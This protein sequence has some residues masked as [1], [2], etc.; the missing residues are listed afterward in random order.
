VNIFTALVGLALILFGASLALHFSITK[1]L[2]T[3]LQPGWVGGVLLLLIQILYI[4]NL[5]LH[6]LSYFLG[7]GF[8]IGAETHLSPTVFTI[9][10]LPAIPILG[11]LPTG[12]HPLYLIGLVL[13]IALS[14]L[15]SFS[16]LRRQLDRNERIREFAQLILAG[17]LLLALISFISSGTLLTSAL[18]PVGVRW[19]PIP[20][21]FATAQF[22][23][24]VIVL[25]IPAGIQSLRN[26]A[27]K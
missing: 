20:A 3:V 5:A 14:L 9:Q 27:A 7:F 13:F 10:Q 19:W 8:A 21:A 17:S 11:G 25:V 18:H 23:F 12:K 6:A 15:I 24:V 22:I 4:P 1:N 16:V 26:R 2:T